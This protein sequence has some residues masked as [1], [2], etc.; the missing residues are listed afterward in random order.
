MF[1]TTPSKRDAAERAADPLSDAYVYR[2]RRDTMMIVSNL[3]RGL[4]QPNMEAL[5]RQMVFVQG[6]LCKAAMSDP[7]V[8]RRVK[9]ML[10]QFQ[11]LT[12]REDIDDRRG[13]RRREPSAQSGQNRQKGAPS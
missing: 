6:Q 3:N 8:P 9:A 1:D 10:L 7:R 4:E 5:K 11:Q 13:S 2:L 12:V